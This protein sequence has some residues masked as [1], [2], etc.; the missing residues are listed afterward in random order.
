MG[1]SAAGLDAAALEIGGALLH[2]GTRKSERQAMVDLAAVVPAN[3]DQVAAVLMDTMETM[4]Q[5][6]QLMKVEEEAEVLV[7]PLQQEL[8]HNLLLL[9]LEE[10]DMDM[11]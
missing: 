5:V 7:V 9:E 4:V 10:V 11:I 3:R 6:L 2:G 1:A 8:L